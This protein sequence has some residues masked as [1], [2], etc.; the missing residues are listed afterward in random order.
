MNPNKLAKEECAN[1]SSGV[2]MGFIFK[3]EL[4]GYIDS[5]I[6]GKPCRVNTERC[7][8]FEAIIIPA[9][10]HS[11]HPNNKPRL[12]AIGKYIDCFDLPRTVKTCKKCRKPAPEMK[13]KEQLCTV[14]RRKNILSSKRRWKKESKVE[15]LCL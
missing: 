6:A 12:K 15:K 1:C 9:V 10:Q 7:S 5:E 13:G 3:D 14:C 11:E 4:N 2:C 8:Y